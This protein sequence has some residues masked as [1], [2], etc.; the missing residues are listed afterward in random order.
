VGGVVSSTQNRNLNA[1]APD[2]DALSKTTAYVPGAG[3]IAPAASVG[4][5]NSSTYG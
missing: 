2:R 4:C 1:P 3:A 5:S